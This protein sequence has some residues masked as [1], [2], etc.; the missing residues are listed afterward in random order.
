MP[1]HVY[2]P[3]ELFSILPFDDF[4]DSDGKQGSIVTMYARFFY[5]FFLIALFSFSIWNTMMGTSLLA[6]PWALQQA[7]LGLG[8][9]LILFMGSVALFTAYRVIESPKNLGECFCLF[10]LNP[11]LFSNGCGR[12]IG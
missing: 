2:V 4:K 3:S 6:M 7:G 10:S 5:P 9:F 1:D 8:V 12:R 11:G